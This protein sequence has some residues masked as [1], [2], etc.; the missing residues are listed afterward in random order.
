MTISICQCCLN[1]SIWQ[2]RQESPSSSSQLPAECATPW[3]FVWS[4][5]RHPT[6]INCAFSFPAHVA[7]QRLH[8]SLQCWPMSSLSTVF[9]RTLWRTSI[10]FYQFWSVKSWMEKNCGWVKTSRN[11]TIWGLHSVRSISS[12]FSSHFNH[13]LKDQQINCSNLALLRIISEPQHRLPGFGEL[14]R[15]NYDCNVFI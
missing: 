8:L 4:K 1:H 13:R 5:N 3:L 7:P 9:W 10:P 15:G 11:V 2:L 12:C 6:S 14:D